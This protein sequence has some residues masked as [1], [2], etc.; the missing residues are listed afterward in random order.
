V[1][2]HSYQTC[3]LRHQTRRE[4]LDA[5]AAGFELA[6]R[7]AAAGNLTERRL[8]QQQAFYEEARLATS[9]AELELRSARERLNVLMGLWGESTDWTAARST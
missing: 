5:A 4:A 1:A 7:L 3:E 9:D 6:Q 8:L 2:F